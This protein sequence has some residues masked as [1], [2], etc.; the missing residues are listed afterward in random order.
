VTLPEPLAT[1]CLALVL[2]QSWSERA[3]TRVTLAE[4]RGVGELQM[5]GPAEL[6]A[7][8][9]TP[10]EL[11]AAAVPALLQLEKPGIDAVV[12]AFA[13]LDA[14]GRARALDVLENAP[15]AD[16]AGIYAGLLDDDDANNR[17]RAEQRL[18][19]CGAAGELALRRA[20]EV[21]AGESGVRLAREL[22][23]VAPALAVELL[24]PRLAA[25]ASEQR[26][27]YRDALS[28]AAR[29][30][31]AQPRA[32]RLLEARELG[33]AAALDVLRALDE[34]LSSLEPEASSAFGRAVQGARTFEH[35][36]LLLVPASRLAKHSPGAAAFLDAALRDP[37]PYLRG[38]AARLVPPLAR[39]A[40]GLLAATRDPGV[41]VRVAATT[42]LGELAQPGASAALVERLRT[43]DWPLVRS[44]AARSLAGVGPSADADEALV[45][46]LRDES[47]D[48]RSAALRGLGQ[49]GAR[50]TVPAIAE[51]FRDARELPTVRA[52]AARA[53]ADLCDSSQLDELTRAARA[54][55][56]DRPSPDD[57]AVG[58]AA[59]AALG[60]IAPADLE[61][62]LAVFRERK[63]G[64]ALS[65]MIDAARN[66]AE[67]CAAS[68]APSDTP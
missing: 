30:P 58:G 39:F 5:L 50:S 53:L 6:V 66:G 60:R 33:M 68:P 63:S 15:C 49:R 38:A 19:G 65:Q 12:G 9:S 27:G 67:R 56:A 64:P 54:L 2:E 55:L 43:D 25:A 62:R 31:A 4:L 28:R 18:R 7:R 48:V 32:R 37:D 26:A 3:D 16:T 8:L 13:A 22:A 21:G 44:A 51:R 40:P 42:R 34:Q 23:L 24:G 47:P 46:A 45:V 36:Y 14:L 57:I 20:F 52:A 61:Q 35:R 59:L 29:D 41:R 1:D 10:G 17:R 11:G